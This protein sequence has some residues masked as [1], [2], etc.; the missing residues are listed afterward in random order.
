MNLC[1][2]GLDCFFQQTD[3]DLR[4]PCQGREFTGQWTRAKALGSSILGANLGSVPSKL[5]VP[6]Q[7]TTL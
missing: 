7:M 6:G 5:C 4:S 1:F 3:Q 2:F